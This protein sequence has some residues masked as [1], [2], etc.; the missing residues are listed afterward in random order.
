MGFNQS[1]STLLWV[2]ILVEVSPFPPTVWKT[3]TGVFP[4]GTNDP[5]PTS[6]DTI[7]S[8]FLLY[9]SYFD[10]ASTAVYISV[11]NA[12]GTLVLISTENPFTLQSEI[13][14]AVN[15]YGNI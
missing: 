6:I 1:I 12:T 7:G 15:L 2:L 11:W 8:D 3:A 4:G 13:P 14:I 5:Q 9:T 10:T